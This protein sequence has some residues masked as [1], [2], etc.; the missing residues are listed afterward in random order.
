MKYT[1]IDMQDHLQRMITQ[2]EFDHLNTE[3]KIEEMQAELDALPKKETEHQKQALEQSISEERDRAQ[4]L[5]AR[6][7]RIVAKL[8]EN[9]KGKK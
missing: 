2:I 9:D 7:K 5:S 6:H 8:K 3:L 1:T 4:S